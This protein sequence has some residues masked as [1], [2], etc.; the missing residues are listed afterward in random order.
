MAIKFI[1]AEARFK[2]LNILRRLH[3]IPSQHPV[4]RHLPRLLD[5]LEHSGPN[6]THCCLILEVLGESMARFAR[7]N[8]NQLPQPLA[9]HFSVQLISLL[10]FLHKTCGY[11]HTGKGPFAFLAN[12]IRYRIAEYLAGVASES[13][14][15]FTPMNVLEKGRV[16]PRLERGEAILQKR[17][18]P[19][20][21]LLSLLETLNR[22]N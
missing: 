3:M 4:R 11:V 20:P 18:L 2:E 14:G 7:R 1:S 10:D 15:G 17:K 21:S 19:P 12:P 9:K 5:H 6:G 22:F 16:A 8:C 13:F